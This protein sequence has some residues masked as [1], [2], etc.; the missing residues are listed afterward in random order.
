MTYTKG[1]PML[2]KN[3]AKYIIEKLG[4]TKPEDIDLTYIAWELKTAIKETP[5]Q[6]YEVRIVKLGQ[7][8]VISVNKEIVEP[9]KKR[10]VVAH[11]LGHLQLEHEVNQLALCSDNDLAARQKGNADEYDSNTFAGELLM[12]ESIFRPFTNPD[13][14]PEMLREIANKFQTSFMSSMIRYAEL[15]PDRVAVVCSQDKAIKWAQVSESF[16][17]RI[18]I[19][20][21][22]SS[23]T[24]ARDFYSGTTLSSKFESVEAEGWITDRKVRQDALVKEFSLAMPTYNSV[25][26]V[27]WLDRAV[28]DEDDDSD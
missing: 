4:I 22:L 28:E 7:N 15:T 19:G 18:E 17:H 27:V 23:K 24:H 26:S 13:P 10:F 12:P 14:S 8:A 20:S 3:R 2:A 1:L 9:G 6:G 21:M 11:E 25:L 16:G 5:L